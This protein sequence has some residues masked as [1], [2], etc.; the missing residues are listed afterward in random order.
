LRKAEEDRGR[1]ADRQAEEGRHVEEGRGRQ[2]KA[3]RQTKLTDGRTDRHDAAH[4]R[5]PLFCESA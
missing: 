5:F 3:G 4:S 2:G 1:Q